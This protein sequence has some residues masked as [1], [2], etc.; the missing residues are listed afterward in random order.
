MLFPK[1][2]ILNIFSLFLNIFSI[3]NMLS[4]VLYLSPLHGNGN[5]IPCMFKNV[6]LVVW[7]GFHY[8]V[9]DDLSFDVARLAADWYFRPPG[10]L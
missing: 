1:G 6:F 3:L 8:N 10:F 4:C 2:L 7:F 5:Y 9:L